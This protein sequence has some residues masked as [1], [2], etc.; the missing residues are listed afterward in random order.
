M[1]AVS[2]RIWRCQTCDVAYGSRWSGLMDIDGPVRLVSLVSDVEWERHIRNSI[3]PSAVVRW[4]RRVRDLDTVDGLGAANLVLWQLAASPN[5]ASTLPSTFRKVRSVLPSTPIVLYC[6]V[7]PAVAQLIVLA[8]KLGVHRA[9]LR[10]YDDLGRVLTDALHESRCRRASDEILQHLRVHDSVR[11]VVAYCLRQAFYSV[12][13]VDR[14]ARVFQVDRKT[15]YNHLRQSGLPATSALISWSRLLTAGWLL[16]HGDR[17]VANVARALHFASASEFRGMLSR[18]VHRNATAIRGA[19]ALAAI[20][21]AF[22]TDRVSDHVSMSVRSP[23]ARSGL[24]VVYDH[25]FV[26]SPLTDGGSPVTD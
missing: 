18:Y 9:A 25:P 13:S 19:G 24:S 2:F 22:R 17:T 16:D 20:A 6:A 7:A 1:P 12:L 21:E 10:G 11:P 3:G 8:A 5:A 15:L 23:V 4:V 14:L 26:N